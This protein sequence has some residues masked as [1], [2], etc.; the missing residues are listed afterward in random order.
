MHH[1][2]TAAFILGLIGGIF[3]LLGGLLWL[4][5]ASILSGF[6]G[7]GTFGLSLAAL[8]AVGT[9]IGLLTIVF[10][11]LLYMRPQ[12]H[13]IFGILII[14]LAVVSLWSSFFGGFVIGFIL[15]LIGGILGLVFKPMAGMMGGPTPP[16]TMPASA[17]GAMT[18]PACGG[19]VNMQTRTCTMCG[20][21][22]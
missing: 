10:S 13:V 5:V 12:Q 22:V 19:A 3:Q 14:V 7:L 2:P 18:C 11:V 17:P 20:R 15:A 21:A 9:L 8:G 4:A 16:G 1:K 6:I